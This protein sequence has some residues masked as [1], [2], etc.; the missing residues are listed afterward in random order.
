MP[1][2]PGDM[3][4]VVLDLGCGAGFNLSAWG[5]TAAD[6]VI[7]IDIDKTSLAIAKTRFCDRSYLQA[8]AERLP[9]KNESF[10]RVIA[11]LSLPYTNIQHVL[12]EVDRVLTPSGRLS[13]SLHPPSFTVSKL[14]NNAIPKAIPT[15]FRLYVIANGVVFHFTG[16]VIGF[17]NGRTESLQT[18]RGM[19]LA[20][21]RANFVDFSFRN[22]TGPVGKTFIVEARKP[23]SN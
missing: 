10:D 12:G 22:G 23:G 15:I 5:V 3:A 14:L 21:T 16:R 7:G 1:C 13:L 8:R 2:I 20:L 9:F 4:L 6:K 17:L 11:P 18:E 19:R